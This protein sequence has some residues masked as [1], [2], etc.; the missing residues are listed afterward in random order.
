MSIVSQEFSD[1]VIGWQLPIAN[2]ELRLS[3]FGN[4]FSSQILV[5]KTALRTNSIT[6]QSFY[7]QALEYS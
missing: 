2:R 4:L 7:Y 3:K 1:N 6:T 5:E